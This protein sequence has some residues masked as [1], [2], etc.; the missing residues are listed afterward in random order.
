MVEKVKKTLK[1]EE[2]SI[3]FILREK[4]E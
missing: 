4:R 3:L 1:N 2:Y